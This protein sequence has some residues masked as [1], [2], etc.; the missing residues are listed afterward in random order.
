[1]AF[2][3]SQSKEFAH[4]KQ[5]VCEIVF[6]QNEVVWL[7]WKNIIIDRST[8]TRLCSQWNL[9]FSLKDRRKAGYMSSIDICCFGAGRL[10]YDLAWGRIET[11]GAIQLTLSNLGLGRNYQ[12]QAVLFSCLLLD[13]WNFGIALSSQTAELFGLLI[14]EA[15]FWNVLVLYGHCPNSF[16]PP[17]PLSNM[18]KKVP[19]TILASLYIPPP[20]RAMPIYKQHISKRGFPY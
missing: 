7:F 16:R 13:S 8:Q 20:L 15:P 11:S 10:N 18:R 4:K 17:D 3:K 6:L 1:M 5:S 19:Q 2:V 12:T 9:V 14:R